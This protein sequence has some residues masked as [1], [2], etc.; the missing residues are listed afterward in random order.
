M[1]V[2]QPLAPFANL[3][4]PALP[5]EASPECR[6]GIKPRRHA[7]PRYSFY[8]IKSRSAAIGSGRRPGASRLRCLIS[9]CGR[10]T[11]GLAAIIAGGSRIIG[12]WRRIGYGGIAAAMS[13][14]P[15]AAAAREHQGQNRHRHEE[16]FAGH[17]NASSCQPRGLRP[18]WPDMWRCQ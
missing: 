1:G 5:N 14:A 10:A 8:P 3:R 12:R 15:G 16:T 4:D 7:G 17:A 6:R 2:E 11:D 13:I 18:P 9:A